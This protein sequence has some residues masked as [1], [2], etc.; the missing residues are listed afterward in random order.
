MHQTCKITRERRQS[1]FR[2]DFP[3]RS[4]VF[5]F[6]RLDLSAE[7]TQNSYCIKHGP[8]KRVTGQ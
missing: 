4:N 6:S 1:V 3:K 7:V 8:C 5:F 2:N